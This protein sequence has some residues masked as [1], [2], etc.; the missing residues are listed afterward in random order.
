MIR[1]LA[2]NLAG[3][4][5][6][7]TS[8]RTPPFMGENA[9]DDPPYDPSTPPDDQY[10]ADPGV[11][12]DVHPTTAPDNT[13][14]LPLNRLDAPPPKASDLAPPPARVMTA[15]EKLAQMN[16]P[17]ALPKTSMKRQLG[18]AALSL[19]PG[20]NMTDIP[21]NVAYPGISDYTRKRQALQNQVAL[22]HQGTQEDLTRLQRDT[23]RENVESLREART[24]NM[25]TRQSDERRKE[26]AD[27]ARAGGV[28]INDAN[29]PS[30]MAPLLSH[31]DEGKYFT[32]QVN[33]QWYKVP[34]PEERSR[35]QNAPR[36]ARDQANRDAKA[37]RPSAPLSPTT[38][39]GLI[40]IGA[41]DIN[42]P[43]PDELN[44][45]A[46]W[47]LKQRPVAKGRA[48]A[49][50]GG[51]VASPA[52]TQPYV[53]GGKSIQNPTSDSTIDTMAWEYINT[54]KIP[55]TGM[56]AGKGA[57]KRE[58]AVGRAGE[59]L[60]DLSLTPA[61]LPALRGKIKGDTGALAKIT[62]TGSMIGQFE[63][64]LTRNAE[65]AKQ[66]SKNYPRF[67][68]RLLNRVTNAWK[69][70]IAG[71]PEANNLAAQLHG[72]AREWG[73]IMQG[74]T[75]TAGVAIT[76]ARADDE[77]F[78]ALGDGALNSLIDNVIVPDAKNRRAAID[79]TKAALFK[80][81]RGTAQGMGGKTP[82]SGTVNMKA[83]D[84]SVK[85]VPADQVDHYKKLGA[86]VV[87]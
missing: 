43:T 81:L 86:V 12:T 37:N 23:Q 56:S 35:Q 77:I 15:R 38:R 59:L 62:T 85:P 24:G 28:P 11:G 22:E 55:F 87:Q 2:K 29:L 73:K 20:V 27:I 52:T 40:A 72:L 41:K 67:D 65:L 80:D 16:E 33:G 64:T 58:A 13:Q 57:N 8:V 84:G 3:Y 79:E 39:A 34:T 18:A 70:K 78:K 6:A 82:T 75:G 48:A 36:D 53:P 42:S 76:E 74:S 69:Q 66:L 31:E 14:P 32:K 49:G 4:G 44:R 1:G 21:R 61:D 17:D 68:S 45:G 19:I 71:D 46:A 51:G 26:A 50:G 60:A 54:G 25:Q 30:G 47:N 7:P 5:A 63:G 10:A 9:P 83:P